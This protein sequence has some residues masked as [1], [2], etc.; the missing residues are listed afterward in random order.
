M[1]ATLMLF[2]LVTAACGTAVSD[3]EGVMR[4][5]DLRRTHSVEAVDWPD[6]AGSG[7]EV[8]SGQGL[9][10]IL[11]P[12]DVVVT[13]DFRANPGRGGGL[14]GSPYDDR[15]SDLTIT[16][17]R[18]PVGEV[19]ERARLYARQFGLGLGDLPR[20]AEANA[21]GLALG[22]GGGSAMSERGRLEPEGPSAQLMTQAFPD[23][24]AVLRV[25]IVWA[26]DDSDTE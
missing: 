3:S 2:A 9:E 5:W 1:V 22:A 26:A 18:E 6:D 24:D 11:L 25:L 23:G 20:W 7:F 10:R 4:M 15:L 8:S 12:G 13:G 14:R 21:A 19:L 17:A 16:F